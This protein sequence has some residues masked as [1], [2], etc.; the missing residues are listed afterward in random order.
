MFILP[1]YTYMYVMYRY[2]FLYT[3]SFSFRLFVR[4]ATR[5]ALSEATVQYWIGQ[6]G[7]IGQIVVGWMDG[8]RIDRQQQDRQLAVG[9]M[10][11]SRIDRQQQVGQIAV[12]WIDSRGLDGQQQVGWI[13]AGQMD[14]RRLDGQYV[15]VYFI[16][17]L[18]TRLLPIVCVQLY[19]IIV[20]TVTRSLLGNQVYTAFIPLY[21]FIRSINI[22][23]TLLVINLI[24]LTLYLSSCFGRAYA[25]RIIQ[26]QQC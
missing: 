14:S 22:Y 18:H 25:R 19:Y 16:F 24:T 23:V 10:D 13:A 4:A 1:Q 7:R 17:V 26:V 9:W 21:I 11:S 3:K 15:L 12:G 5:T 2:V 6:N 20:S 8:S